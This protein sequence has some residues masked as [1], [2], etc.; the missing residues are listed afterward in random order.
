MCSEGWQDW[1]GDVRPFRWLCLQGK[2]S[3]LEF[4]AGWQEE[5]G[6]YLECAG[7]SKL[8]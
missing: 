1:S 7:H 5:M 8:M 3:G 4:V 6:C 2:D